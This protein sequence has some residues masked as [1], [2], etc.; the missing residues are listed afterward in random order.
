MSSELHSTVAMV[1][2]QAAAKADAESIRNLL[3]PE[4]VFSTLSAGA[5]TGSVQGPE[6]VIDRLALT[7]EL[8]DVL[9]LD[10]IDIYSGRTGAVIHYRISA[11]RE[12]KALDQQSL[13][14]LRFKDGL[15]L[16]AISVP[17]SVGVGDEFWSLDS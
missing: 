17:L 12:M 9:T 6:A 8:V 3:A 4:V 11:E 15:V 10:L 13:I 5:L 7:G 16:Q 1:L 2:W 14:V